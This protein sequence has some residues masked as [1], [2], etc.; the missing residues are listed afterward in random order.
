MTINT[1]QKFAVTRRR[2]LLAVLFCS[3]AAPAAALDHVPPSSLAQ[4]ALR[5]FKT[6]PAVPGLATNRDQA[7]LALKLLGNAAAH[8]IDPHRYKVDDLAFRLD[9]LQD[10]H[11]TAAFDRDLGAAMLQ[12]LAD[13][14]DGRIASA[15]RPAADAAGA[16]DPVLQLRKAIDGGRLEDAV[17]AAVPRIPL[18]KRVVAALAQYRA[19]A[20]AAP[21]W[22]VLPA[23]V[24]GALRAG[25]P[26]QGAALLRERLR[27]L[28][29]MAP[30]HGSDSDDTYTAELAEA[31]RRF[32]ARHG[33]AED[34]IL[35]AGTMAALSVPPSDR[36]AQLALTLERLRWLPAFPPHGRIIAVNIPTYRLWAFD[37]TDNVATPALEMRVIVGAGGRTPTPLFI[38]DMRYLEFDPYWNVPPSIVR[39][40]IVPKLARNAAYLQQNDME[41][42]GSDGGVLHITASESLARLRA[43]SARVRQRPGPRNVLG[44]VKFAMPNPMN[45]YLHSTSASELFGRTRRDLSHGC[46]RVEHPAE[47]A[48]FVLADP[49]HWDGASVA[50]AMRAA[51]NRFVKLPEPIPVVLFYA[52]ALVDRQGRVLFAD[53]IYGID[54]PL[55][56][57]LQRQ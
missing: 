2:A 3:L 45:I 34:G 33:L 19:L 56:A 37:A 28:G 51:R 25:E 42:V 46:I 11:A 16:Y 21:Q 31:V 9:H 18:Y 13:L 8:G 29:D 22:P 50:A 55:M 53:D 24:H 52:T 43:G 48:Q 41:L 20:Q 27:V 14:H 47:L 5:H 40:E 39:Q 7:Q 49:L 4:P 44:D 23:A 10:D 12:Y 1:I 32:Q 15:Y 26:Y 6:F 35:G 30:G 54:K 36:A 57:A 38:G 17:N